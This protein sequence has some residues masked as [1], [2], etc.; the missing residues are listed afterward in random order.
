[1]HIKLSTT[2]TLL[3]LPLIGVTLRFATATFAIE[4]PDLGNTVRTRFNAQTDEMGD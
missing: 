2:L 4:G 1:M 3:S